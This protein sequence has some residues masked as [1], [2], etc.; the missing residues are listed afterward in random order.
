[1]AYP[2]MESTLLEAWQRY[3]N[4]SANR[5]SFAESRSAHPPVEQISSDSEKADQIDDLRSGRNVS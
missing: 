2:G 5:V 1:M 4:Q 3:K